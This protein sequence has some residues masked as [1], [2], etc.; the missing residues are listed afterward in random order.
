MGETQKYVVYGMKAKC[1][2]GT[3]ENYLSTDTGHGVVYQGQPVLNANDHQKDIN[4]THFGECKSKKIFEEAKKE[5]DEKYKAEEGDGFF[6]KIGKGIAKTV[7]KAAISVKEHLMVNKCDLD[8]PLPWTF[9]SKDHMIDGAPALTMESQ[10]ACRYGGIISIVSQEDVSEGEGI[11]S[12]NEITENKNEVEQQEFNID[13]VKKLASQWDIEIGDADWN[14]LDFIRRIASPDGNEFR[15]EKR[16]KFIS[17]YNEVIEDAANE[18]DIPVF[19]MAGVVYNEYSG[20]PESTDDIAYLVREIDWSG[21]DWVDENLT[22]TKNPDLTSFGHVSMQV[23]RAAETLGL[24]SEKLSSK[25]KDEIIALLKD[26]VSNIYLAAKHLEDLKNI[27]YADIPSKDL[28]EADIKSI[29]TRFNRGPDLTKEEIDG[30][31]IYGETMYA[32][33]DFIMNALEEEHEK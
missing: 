17:K 21:P 9:T 16:Q 1:S 14:T 24:D 8:T 19:L 2:E 5:A 18:F 26:P 15:M 30:N 13:T 29:A 6:T 12:E 7:T 4:L 20:K 22:I 28:T 10:C 3:M 23:R 32:N 27:D 11:E 25:E 31:L 33:K